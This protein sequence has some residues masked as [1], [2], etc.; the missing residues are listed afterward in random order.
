M[1]AFLIENDN[2]YLKFM[3]VSM[4]ILNFTMWRLFKM[5]YASGT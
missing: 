1:V 3:T 2:V 4:C 5:L